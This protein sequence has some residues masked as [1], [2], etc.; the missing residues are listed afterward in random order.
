[1]ANSA[2]WKSN[3]WQRLFSIQN[4]II[5]PYLAITVLV[6]AVGTYIVTRLVAGSLQE[7]LSNQLL[8]SGRVASDSVVRLEQNHIE[9]LRLMALASGTDTAIETRNLDSLQILIDTLGTNADIPDA[10]ILDSEGNPLV[11][12]GTFAQSDVIYRRLP[13][14]SLVLTQY[15]DE[16]GDKFSGISLETSP[17]VFYVAGPV[18]SSQD[19]NALVGVVVVGTPVDEVLITLKRESLADL[20]L[21]DQRGEMI[22][23]TFITSDTSRFARL[24]APIKQLQQF[25]LQETQTTEAEVN[26]RTYQGIYAPFRL[27]TQTVGLMSVYLPSEFIVIEGGTSARIFSGLFGAAAF[28][29][30]FMGLLVAR[31][32]VNPVRT[33]VKIAQDVTLGD[34]TRRSRLKNQDEIGFL[35]FTFDIMTQRLEQRT[36][37]LEAEAARLKTILAHS[38]TGMVM[39]TPKGKLAFMNQAA[40]R[41]LNV[42]TTSGDEILAVIHGLMELS[43]RDKIEINDYILST[44]TT[45]V[46]SSQTGQFIGTLVALNDITQEEMTKQLKDRFITQ[47]SHE[48]RTPL[49]AIKGYGDLLETTVELGRTPR[50]EHL[51]GLLKQARLLDRMI[52]ELLSISQMS[53]GTFSVRRH[54]LD[55]RHLLLET[56]EAELPPIQAAGLR[57]EKYFYPDPCWIQGDAQRLEW[58]FHQVFDNAVK[59][60]PSGGKIICELSGNLDG[61]FH[62]VIS[63]TGTGIRPVDQRYAFEAYFR[64]EAVTP[65]GEVIDPRGMG[66]GLYIVHQVVKAHR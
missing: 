22:G 58:A 41:F 10:A 34:L 56:L 53:A 13:G 55:L 17:P 16:S 19:S 4:R 52:S 60:T 29:I 23:T 61:K 7:R 45:R 5:V 33:L 35:G 57:L 32:I 31:T 44:I 63:D 30:I 3:R 42:N 65:T 11:T 39:V 50:Q 24:T 21:Y 66:L 26:K 48:L 14:V 1:M 28:L 36:R 2:R 62:V 25:E 64:R 59:Y 51:S 20:V 47:V 38:Q 40:M 27:R 54:R 9:T 18:I 43:T 6:A 8:E 12:R 46:T 49:T 37:Q 15:R